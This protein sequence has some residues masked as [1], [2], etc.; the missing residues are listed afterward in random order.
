VA[1][2]P[3]ATSSP[4][5]S[6]SGGQRRRAVLVA[7][8]AV[9]AVAVAAGLA[10]TVGGLGGPGG[11]TSPSGSMAADAE[12][13][14]A[15]ADLSLV[16][17]F[18]SELPAATSTPGGST[19]A[20]GSAEPSASATA[21]GDGIKANRIRIERLGIDLRIVEGDGIDAPMNKA[22]H[23]PGSAW[24]GAGSNVYIY[25]HAQKGMFINLWKAQV[26]DV[27]ELDLAD[28]T[29]RRYV[30]D[31][32]LPKVPWDA[33][34]YVRPTKTEQLTLQTSTSYHPTSPRFIVIALPAP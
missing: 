16:P 21:A 11:T 27:I 14:S 12:A 24:P 30:V 19:T 28:G 9:S 18:A 29:A 8:L 22:A 6:A 4:P 17:V 31:K 7:A 2:R 13:T 10:I 26:G 33:M 15:D 20:T 34:K 23:Y 25:G 5:P 32:V 1:G 3:V